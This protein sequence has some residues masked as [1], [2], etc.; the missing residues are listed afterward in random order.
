MMQAFDIGIRIAAAS[1]SIYW[2]SL[3][4]AMKMAVM[5]ARK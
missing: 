5:L 2:R 4:Q 3:E 1:W